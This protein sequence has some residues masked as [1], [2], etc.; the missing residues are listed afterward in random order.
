MA[1]GWYQSGDFPDALGGFPAAG[2]LVRKIVKVGR[3]I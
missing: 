3:P 1:S 2:V